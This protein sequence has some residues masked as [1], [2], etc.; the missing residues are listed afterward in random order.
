MVRLHFRKG[1]RVASLQGAKNI[2]GLVSQ[3]VKIRTDGQVTV[4]HGKASFSIKPGVRRCR[5]KRRFLRTCRRGTNQSGGLSPVHGQGASCTPNN[6][7]QK[8]DSFV[9][10]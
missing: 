9:N 10:I 3:L 1:G 6:S 4:R 5:A 8:R 2:L 7:L